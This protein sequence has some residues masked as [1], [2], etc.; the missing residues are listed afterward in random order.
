LKHICWK[1]RIKSC[2]CKGKLGV[3]AKVLLAKWGT[4]S[5]KNQKLYIEESENR[6]HKKKMLKELPS[7]IAKLL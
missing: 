3:F 1:N 6:T 4:S 7:R 5:T 2:C